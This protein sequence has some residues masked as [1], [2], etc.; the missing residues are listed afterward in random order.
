MAKLVL[1]RDIFTDEFTLGK[2]TV[3]GVHFCYTVEDMVRTEKV[4]GK[5]AIPFGKYKILVTL[6]A[7]FKKM[8]PLLLDVPNFTGVRIHSGNTAAD[9]AGCIICGLE[10]T[11]NGVAKSRD[12]MNKLMSLLENSQKAGEEITIEIT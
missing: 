9:S 8:L 4:A 3:D 1:K 11:K 7:R 2:I 12:A 10:R 5:T 6:S